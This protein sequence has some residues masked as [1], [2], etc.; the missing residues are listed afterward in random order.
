MAIKRLRKN[1]GVDYRGS[2]LEHL[3]R[4]YRASD[5][6]LPEDSGCWCKLAANLTRGK[7]GFP[8]LGTLSK[9]RSFVSRL[10]RPCRR[11]KYPAM[12]P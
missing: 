1:E 11:R 8:G 3:L 10:S 2:T 6:C 4:G 9:K 7:D 12:L 5:L